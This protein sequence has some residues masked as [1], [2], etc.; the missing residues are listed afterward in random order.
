VVDERFD[1]V[2]DD[3]DGTATPSGGRVWRRVVG[4]GAIELR[5]DH[6]GVRADRERPN[7]GRT[8][9]T[10]PWDDPGHADVELEMT[11]P[12][13]TRGEGHQGRCGVVFWQDPDNY[14]VVNFFVDD[15]FD[16]A[17]ISTFYHLAGHEDMYDAVWTLVPG[18]LW[19]ER[20]TLRTAFDGERFLAWTN[21]EPC[22]V[23]A[24]RDV[25]PDTPP[26]SIEQVGIIVNREWG[27]DTGSLLH[28]FGASRRLDAT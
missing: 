18:V 10:I 25:Y 26:L 12:G 6:A 27:D 16:G 11:I 8:V 7:P 3:L 2:A 15:V 5:G 13:T 21:G 14:L 17:S 23:R 19:G 4:E 9:F 20:C 28:R 24:L 22:L 1:A